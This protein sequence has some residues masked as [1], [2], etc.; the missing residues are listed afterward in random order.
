MKKAVLISLFVSVLIFFAGCI[1]VSD[2]LDYRHDLSDYEVKKIVRKV[3]LSQHTI[4]R[5]GIITSDDLEKLIETRSLRAYYERL[6]C[7]EGG[8]LT[9]TLS[10]GTFS[11]TLSPGIPYYFTYYDCRYAPLYFAPN[12][13]NGAVEITYHQDIEDR[14][15]KL[16]DFSIDYR[17]TYLETDTAAVRIAG[18]LGVHYDESYREHI[19][20]L[21]FS[22]TRLEI[23]NSDYYHRD[24]FNNIVL[25]Y[26]IDTQSY[27]Y[28]YSYSGT[29]DNTYLGRLTFTTLI[30]M[31]GYGAHN[32]YY[33][34]FKISN[35]HMDLLVIPRDDY[36]VDIVVENH[37]DTI[38]NHTIHT[39]WINIGL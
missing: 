8:Y 27:H 34:R 10:D 6:E 13:L 19:L 4:N 21:I 33:G 32:P 15:G 11:L 36:Y 18:R 14:Y 5:A 9:F 20:S 17:D 28:R 23:E 24:I 7:D 29:L 22:S 1:I 12:R 31:E 35:A 26:T 2:R 38:Q 39:T 3:L 16:L 37:Y 25:D 30:P